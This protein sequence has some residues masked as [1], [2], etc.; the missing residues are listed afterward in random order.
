MQARL[1]YALGLGLWSATAGAHQAAAPAALPGELRGHVQN[2][3]FDAVSSI[4]GLPLGVRGELLTLFGG[5]TL[6]ISESNGASPGTDD[7]PAVRLPRRLVT[8]GCSQEDCLVYYEHGTGPA[9]T[10][11]VLLLHWTPN[12]TRFE[13]GGTAPGGLKT[14]ESVR[15]AVLSGAIKGSAGPW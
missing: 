10:W 14:I 8:A 11:R 4:R 6:D 12:Q 7:I 1:L 9:H 2:A 15:A 13:W 3:R 5:K